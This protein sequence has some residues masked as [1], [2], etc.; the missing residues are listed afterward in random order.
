MFYKANETE[1]TRENN[2]IG[3]D[4]AAPHC[5]NKINSG[6]LGTGWRGGYITTN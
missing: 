4:A 1:S 5:C 2:G 6:A 3:R